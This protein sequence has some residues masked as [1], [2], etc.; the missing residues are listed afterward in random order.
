MIRHIVLFKYKLETPS[1]RRHNFVE[2][3]RALPRQ[4]PGIVAAELGEDFMHK[5]RS[6][7]VA[8]I[9]TFQDR[10]ALEAYTPHPIHQQVVEESHRINEKVVSADF[11]IE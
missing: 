8:L 11:E 10:A 5:E 1:P 7:D 9:F 6:F 4:I 3:L 2:M